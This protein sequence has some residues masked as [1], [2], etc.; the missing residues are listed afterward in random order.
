MIVLPC[1]EIKKQARINLMKLLIVDKNFLSSQPENMKGKTIENPPF[2][3]RKGDR[4][5]WFYDPP[6][7]VT[8]VFID[9]EKQEI[10]VAVE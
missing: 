4:I 8:D 6:P 9:Y 5:A 2:V 7:T 3:P 1:L 10:L